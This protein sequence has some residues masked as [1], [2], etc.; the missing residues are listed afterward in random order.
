[1]A[2]TRRLAAI[3]FTD[4]VGSTALAQ[5]DEAGALRLRDEQAGLVRPLFAVHECREIKSMGDGFLAEFASALRAAQCA[6]DIQHHLHERNMEPGRTPIQLRIGVHLGD[7]EQR[8]SDIFGDAVNIA[9][10]IEPLA[11]PGGVCISGEVFSQIRN[12]VS[13]TFER[14]PPTALKGL[15][16]S[17]EVYRLVLPWVDPEP[18]S[19]AS[20][21]TGIAVLPFTNISPDPNDAYFADGLTE[22]LITVL[23]QLLD[24]RV[25]SRTSVMLYRAS[26]KS[27]SQIGSELGVSSILE[28]SVRKAGNRLRVTVQLID[29]RSDGHLWARTFDRELND[30]F[31]VQAEIAQ[32]VSES[33]KVQLRPAERARPEVRPPVRSDSYL[34]SLRGRTLMHQMNEASYQAAKEQFDLAISLDPSNAA[35]YSGLS[36]L[37]RLHG[38]SYLGMSPKVAKE[39]GQRLAERAL[40]LDPTLAEAHA[41]AAATLWLEYDFAGGEREF[42]RA[43]ALNPSYSQAHHWYAE[44]LS[45]QLRTD[46]ALEEW[47]LA[48]GTDPLSPFN[49]AHHAQLLIWLGKYEEAFAKLGK[50]AELQPNSPEYWGSL[51]SYHRVRGE[52]GPMLTELRRMEDSSSDRSEKRALRIE[53]HVFAGEKEKARTMLREEEALPEATSSAMNFAFLYAA[54]GDVNDCFR[55]LEQAYAARSIGFHLLRLDPL[56][57]TVRRD[58]RFQE[59]LQK[60]N[61]A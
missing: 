34:A 59:L 51:C 7:V 12:K 28:G 61:L 32:Q 13:N 45:W 6:I 10:R 46:E 8:E 37:V 24:L 41:S 21:L 3:M 55:W 40:E 49:L 5:A 43:L 1:V 52:F 56:F 36:D 27:A 42:R 31:S 4:M 50:L 20:A 35:A 18:R 48:D 9:S 33:L 39:S 22:E 29:A 14:L 57:E 11:P 47:A 26:P 23:S 17:L 30:V 2:S 44:L 25:I 53:Q 54:L 15:Q 60:A 19:G 16:T 38:A 58:P